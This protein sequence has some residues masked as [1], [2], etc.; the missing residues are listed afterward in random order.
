MGHQFRLFSHMRRLVMILRTIRPA[1]TMGK[2]EICSIRG[3]RINYGRKIQHV[4]SMLLHESYTE[5]ALH[6]IFFSKSMVGEL[7]G[8]SRQPSTNR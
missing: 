1:R 8:Y 3:V 4:E 6:D 7:L 2:G 5:I